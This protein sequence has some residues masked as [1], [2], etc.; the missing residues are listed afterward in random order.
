MATE[1]ILAPDHKHHKPDHKHHKPDHNNYITV[2]VV[3][4]PGVPQAVLGNCA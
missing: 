4:V 1:D 3:V 2:V